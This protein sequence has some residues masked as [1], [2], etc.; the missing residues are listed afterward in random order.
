LT[1]DTSNSAVSTGNPFADLLLGNPSSFGQQDRFLKYYN[2]YK[3]LEPYFQDDWHVTPR[4]TLNLGV[5]VS[6]FG[7]YREKQRQAFNFDPSRYVFGQ[8]TINPDGTV[9]FL[10]KDN[11]T[12]SV[13]DL[14]NG[15]VQ[16]GVTPGVPVSCMQGHL[17]NP[18][19][20]IGFAYDPK[21]DGKTA[22]RGGYGIFY[23]HAN[24]NEG[25]TESLEN[26]PPLANASTLNFVAPLGGYQNIGPG[27]GGPSGQLPLSVNAIPTKAQW[28]YIQQWHLDVQRQLPASVVA[29]VSY[30]G[31]KGTHLGRQLDLNQLA[32]LPLSLNPYAP[33]EPMIT[34]STQ[35]GF[36]TDCGALT[37]NGVPV[38]GQAAI[39]LDVACGDN[40]DPFRRYL[41]YSDI[42]NLQF[43]A[44]SI[45]HALQFSARRDLGQL[46]LSV[47]YTYSHSIDDSSDRFDGSFVNSFNPASNRASSNFDQRH[48]L[49]IGYDW[50]LPFFKGRGLTN[51][52]LGGW[53]YSGITSF[54]T[55]SPFS[56]TYSDVSDNAGVANGVGTSSRPDIVGDP[57]S[58]FP[59]VPLSGLKQQ[60]YNP[61]AFA[62][63]RGL[64]FGT[65]GRNILRNPN[66]LNFDMALFKHFAITE[67]MAFEFRAEAFNVFNHFEPGNLGGDSG[68]AGGSGDTAFPANDF[69]YI[70]SAHNPRILQLA[71]KF[72][73]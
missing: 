57:N 54:N 27:N 20:R 48:I 11:G 47:A 2:R 4:L 9:N 14:P 17:F 29:T 5:R 64:T 53:E 8:T 72:I 35:P 13:N 10:T 46:Q 19:P 33:G 28:P 18:A 38:T 26:S 15:I 36:N 56:I 30:V 1:F 12:P 16:C 3:I 23:E 44:S 49:N 67:S 59:Q 21:G 45:Y 65:A 41:G 71:L 66:R 73:F 60:F 42:S 55:G 43:K 31:S 70:N 61:G 6:L 52:I 69:L 63:P 68:S 25:N 51:K 62:P 24:G 40:P 34:D 37:V 50:N 7:T 32:P 39:N 58:S 22:I